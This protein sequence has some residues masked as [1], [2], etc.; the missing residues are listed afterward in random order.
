MRARVYMIVCFSGREMV[1]VR[2][3]VYVY[4]CVCLYV[5]E[6]EFA[7]VCVLVREEHACVRAQFRERAVPSEERGKKIE[8]RR[9]RGEREGGREGVLER[10]LMMLFYW[11]DIT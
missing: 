11:L 3:Y 2:V 8:R 9:W 4:V 1:C 10:S 5:S 7:S 6:R